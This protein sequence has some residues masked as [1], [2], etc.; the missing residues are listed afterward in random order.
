MNKEQIVKI[1]KKYESYQEQVG[2]DYMAVVDSCYEDV[3]DEIMALHN[4]EVSD[5]FIKTGQVV[6]SIMASQEGIERRR[7]P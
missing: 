6:G 4:S 2:W 5:I 1:L 3:A 7:L